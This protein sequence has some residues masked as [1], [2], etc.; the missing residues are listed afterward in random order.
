MSWW[1]SD[2]TADII[3]VFRDKDCDCAGC[4][5]CSGL[6]KT[7]VNPWWQTRRKAPRTCTHVCMS[8]WWNGLEEHPLGDH[9]EGE[10]C[11]NGKSKQGVHKLCAHCWK[12]WADYNQTGA[13]PHHEPRAGSAPP[14]APRPPLPKPPPGFDGGSQQSS[15]GK[16]KGKCSQRQSS[17]QSSQQTEPPYNMGV[18]MQDAVFSVRTEMNNNHKEMSQKIGQIGITLEKMVMYIDTECRRHPC[19]ATA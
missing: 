2:L 11:S 6:G 17:P 18:M 10:V 5:K 7:P 3:G 9:D 8:K 19:P 14:T 16:G 1:P 12:V 13:N 4:Y 15:Q